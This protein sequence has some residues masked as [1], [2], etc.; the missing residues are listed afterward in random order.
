M[1]ED[2]DRVH[3]GAVSR[4]QLHRVLSELEL[5]SLVSAREF[6]VLYEKFDLVIGGKHDFDYIHFCDILNDYAHFDPNVP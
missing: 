2:Y 3:N 4:S 1:F 6:H 5:G